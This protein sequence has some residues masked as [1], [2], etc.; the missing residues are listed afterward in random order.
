[1]PQMLVVL[2]T[3]DQ[4]AEMKRLYQAGK[5]LS[6]LAHLTGFEPV[7]IWRC[8]QGMAPLA[9]RPPSEGRK[10][11]LSE[12]EL[13]QVR[14]MRAEGMLVRDIAGRFGVSLTSVSRFCKGVKP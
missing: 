4:V 11:R 10:T 14:A 7:M 8:I 12:E 2:P 6:Y 13:L 1:M 9:E 3:P 5:R